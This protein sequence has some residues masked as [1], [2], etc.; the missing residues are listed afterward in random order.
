MYLHKNLH[1]TLS[2]SS[3]NSK[4]FL[5]T[6]SF[7]GSLSLVVQEVIHSQKPNND[8]VSLTP[9]FGHKSNIGVA[10]IQ[11]MPATSF[12]FSEAAVC[13]P[14]IHAQERADTR[15]DTQAQT[16]EIGKIHVTKSKVY[17]SCKCVHLNITKTFS[18]SEIG[19][20]SQFELL[21]FMYF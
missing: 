8:P 10:R 11:T 2:S 12:I 20:I 1:L 21:I 3:S 4:A 13:M 17:F 14:F 6:C 15:T 5:T 19:S 7:V 9:V 16:N 18:S